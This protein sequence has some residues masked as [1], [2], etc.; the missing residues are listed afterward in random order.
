MNTQIDINACTALL[1]A[2]TDLIAA[3]S[4]RPSLTDDLGSLVHWGREKSKIA[5]ETMKRRLL[6]LYPDIGWVGEEQVPHDGD[7]RYWVYDPIDGGYH[8]LQ[9]LPL[10]SSSLALMQ[11]GRCRLGVIYD[12]T[13]GELFVAEEGR[14]ATRDGQ[15]IA[16]RSKPQLESAVL[17]TA[18]PPIAQVGAAEHAQAVALFEAISCKV[19]VVR[20]MA[21]ASLQL[22]YV[23]AGRLDGYF[24]VGNDIPDWLAGA[25][26]IRESGGLVTDLAGDVF[27]WQSEGVLAGSSPT[28]AALLPIIGTVAKR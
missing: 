25:L 4:D 26:M 9:G 22:A 15:P 11:G 17:G 21:S 7:N 27:G 5:A 28:H 24:E 13:L 10:W 6:E 8:F 18:V 19:F 14:G 23:A 1:R 2:A 3:S 20:Q 12:P 16:V